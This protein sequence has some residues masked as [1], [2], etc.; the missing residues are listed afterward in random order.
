[1]APRIASTVA[2]SRSWFFGEKASMAGGISHTLS[3]S[4]PS[5]AYSRREKT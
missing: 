3:R 5:Q 2:W 1:M 4:S